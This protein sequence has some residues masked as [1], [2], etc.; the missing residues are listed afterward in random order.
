M[1]RIETPFEKGKKERT[2]EKHR[3]QLMF[4]FVRPGSLTIFVAGAVVIKCY[5][6]CFC[7]VL[8]LFLG[9]ESVLGDLEPDASLQKRQKMSVRS[10]TSRGGL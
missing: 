9:K 6:N 10:S 3:I 1:K 8:Y 5:T 2:Q 7:C 4:V